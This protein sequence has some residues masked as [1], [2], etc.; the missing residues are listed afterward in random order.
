M[1][2]GYIRTSTVEQAGPDKTS[3]EDQRRTIKGM[4][5]LLNS[6]TPVI[7]E[8]AGV[9]GGTDIMDRPEGGKMMKELEP[10]DTVI[11][12]KLDRMFR[13]AC[14]ALQTAERFKRDGISLIMVDMGTQP[15][16]GDGV[17]KLFFTMLAAVAEF[18]KTRILERMTDGRKSKQAKGGYVG[19]AVPYGFRVEGEATAAKLVPDDYEQQALGLARLLHSEGN[20]LRYIAATLAEK[21]YESRQGTPF[22]ANQ[23]RRMVKSA[24]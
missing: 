14:D 12:A 21:E 3:L 23:I 16:T 7:Y 19:G 9:S 17:A 10:G 1:I 20:S 24:A 11:V 8:D 2:Y 18:E 6:T 22:T 5:M 4:A 15:V 13:S